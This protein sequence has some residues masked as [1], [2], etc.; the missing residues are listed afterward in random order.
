MLPYIHMIEYH[1][2]TEKTRIN[3]EI[4]STQQIKTTQKHIFVL[5]NC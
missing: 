1:I 2:A 4:L 5:F 3:T